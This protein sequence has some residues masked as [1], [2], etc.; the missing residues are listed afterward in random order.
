M[1]LDWLPEFES[2]PRYGIRQLDLRQTL[3]IA[4]SFCDCFFVDDAN[5]RV[6]G[7]PRP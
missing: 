6:G 7:K 1:T 3:G 4:I 5:S 2:S